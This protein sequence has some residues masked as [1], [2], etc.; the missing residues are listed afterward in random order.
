MKGKHNPLSNPSPRSLPTFAGV[1]VLAL[2]GVTARGQVAI[3]NLWSIAADSRPYMVVSSS[4]TERGVAL[5]PATGHAL[6]ATRT[7][8]NTVIILDAETG[9]ALG[10]LANGGVISGG[11]ML[12]VQVGA[13]DDG[14]IYACNL[15][16]SGPTGL[17]IYRWGSEDTNAPPVVAFTGLTGAGLRYGDS[18]DVRG[19]GIDT[20]IIIS[21]NANTN[22][23]F[24]TTADGTNFTA[25][26]LAITAP[27]ATGDFGKGLCFGAGDSIYGKNWGS[28]NVRHASYD[29]LAG[30]LGLLETITLDSKGVA[31]SLDTNR[32]LMAVVVT[33]TTGTQSEHRFRVYDIANPAAPSRIADFVFPTPNTNN[34]NAIGAVDFGGDKILALDVNNGVMAFRTVDLGEAP[35]GFVS[36]PAGATVVGGGYYTLS[37]TAVGGEPI[38]YQWLLNSSP[39]AGATNKNLLLTNLT[40]S[41]AGTYRAVATN[42]YGSDTSRVATVVIENVPRTDKMTKLWQIAPGER[43]YINTD[44]SQ[45]SL[46]YNQLT[47]HVLV[48]SRTGGDAVHILDGATGA[49]LGTL[50]NGTTPPAG[51]TYAMNMVAVGDDGQI[52][53]CNLTL[54]GTTT[55]LKIYRW[56]DESPDQTPSVVWQGDPGRGNAQRWGDTL[57]VRGS[58]ENTQLLMASRGG[59]L[60]ALLMPG[61][62]SGEPIGLFDVPGAAAGDMGL[63]LTWG[64]GDTFWTT[65]PDRPL[66]QVAID[67]A[68]S[69][70]TTLHVL[71]RFPGV[72]T[73]GADP[74]NRLLAGV[75]LGT[76]DTLR[77]YDV[78]N[79]ANPLLI[80]TEFFAADNL[81]DNGSG[82]VAFGGGCA[83]ALDSNNG[84][85]AL[86]VGPRLRWTQN[87]TILTL[88][89]DGAYTLQSAARVE[90]PYADVGNASSDYQVDIA[91]GAQFFRLRE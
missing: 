47:S 78:G 70:L 69:Y 76:Q 31:L 27:M 12:L 34:A 88:T 7:S 90:G 62:N 8:G 51:G 37:A 73:L 23:A 63:G 86:K 32:N 24:F 21:G 1:A 33:A 74:M 22:V 35:P 29:L 61:L 28:A 39:L 72:C 64:P 59:T 77:L 6:L 15:V 48:V 50:N 56:V 10:R 11:A 82:G 43:P 19:S 83:Y 67:P 42:A 58:A 68:L 41:Q 25:T 81:N 75:V 14:A 53:V 85:I 5:N 9:E 26:Q 57:A 71:T 17:K 49:D 65:A 30:T 80:D 79:P 40:P 45:R 55:P 3:S 38:F 52:Y 54:N 89:W 91:T 84:L 16:T 20:Q 2:A 18:M 13:A 46:A 44:N 36:H 60:V 4:P 87:G 66:R